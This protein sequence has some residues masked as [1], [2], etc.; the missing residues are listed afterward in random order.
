[1]NAPAAATQRSSLKDNL[2][3]AL[4]SGASAEELMKVIS[5]ACAA[6]HNAAWEALSL[7]D[8]YFRRRR[9]SPEVFRAL[10]AHVEQLALGRPAGGDRPAP[11]R[12]ATP[13]SDPRE[14]TGRHPAVHPAAEP[15]AARLQGPPR[16][17]LLLRGRYRLE[18]RLDYG[19][20]VVFQ[21]RDE[22]R[23]GLP[24]EEQRVAI[25]FPEDAAEAQHEFFRA[26]HLSH[27]NIARVIEF[28][29]DGDTAF[30]I[31]ELQH[32]RLLRDLLQQAT[33]LPLPQP[34]ALA[35]VRD[36]AAALEHAHA[37]GVVHGQ[38]D[39]RSVL[40]TQDGSIR[41]LNFGLPRRSGEE[42]EAADDLR[43]LCLIAY[44]LLAGEPAF[45][46]QPLH[47]ALAAGRQLQRSQRLNQRQWQALQRG[48]SGSDESRSVDIAQWLEEMGVRRA[49]AHAAS[50]AEV[51]QRQA[52]PAWRRQLVMGGILVVVTAAL[53]TLAISWRSSP[54][55]APGA[56][57]ST[58]PAAAGSANVPPSAATASNVP[59]AATTPTPSPAPAPV[60]QPAQRPAAASTTANTTLLATAENPAANVTAADARDDGASLLSFQA[61]SFTVAPGESAARIPVRRTG[62]TRGD[63]GFVWWTEGGTA[64]AGDDFVSFGEQRE[65]IAA[66]Q[67]AV[68]LYVPLAGG[69]RATE[70]EFYVTISEPSGGARLG[71]VTRL[72]VIIAAD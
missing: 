66:G 51:M 69:S 63:V 38:L 44:E 58:V 32:G 48:L 64:R 56:V 36:I 35:I 6:S 8:Q 1:M 68:S 50:P 40:V 23:Q 46:G 14:A 27:P 3:S 67:K 29:R 15:A 5:S 16:V 53:V 12:A 70:S 33:H 37:R 42:V 26:Q 4:H 72:R 47:E 71:R 55:Q 13:A 9:I 20:G 60:S 28:D 61:D 57:A 52:P 59:A 65:L 7:I 41:I 21:A 24:D 31:M 54:G 49:A 18:A 30:Y 22:Y 17:G 34:E 45:E 25:R 19:H 62:S 43:A 2:E 11:I 10:K 39:T